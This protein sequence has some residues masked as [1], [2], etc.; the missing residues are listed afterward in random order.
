[1]TISETK[2]RELISSDEGQ[3]H[4][5]KSLLEGPPGR[6]RSRDRRAVRDQIA[7]Q[8]AGFAN[9][10]G[11]V[12]IFG[13]EDDL[14]I[15][16]HTYPADV[17][18]QMLAVPQT[19]LVPPLPNGYRFR[20]DGVELL[21]FEVECAPRAVMVQGDGYPYRIGD[22][23][24]QFS[25][26]KI[27]T[28]KDQGLVES[29]EA[30][31]SSVDIAALD[32]SLLERARDASGATDLSLEDYLVRRRIADRVGA[33]V[34]LREAAVFLF[35]L[36]PETIAHPNASVR[37][38]RV[39]GTERLTGTQ[40]NVQEFP[41]IEGNLPSVLQQARTLLGTLIQRSSR[42]HDLFFQEMPEY[43][44]FAWQEALVNAV[45]HRDYGIQ[46]QSVEV[47]LYDDRLEVWSPGG[48]PPEISI[49]ELRAGDPAHASRNPRI[50]RALADLGV[51]RDQGEGI[52]RMF[53]EMESSFLPLP[54][55]DVVAGR[56]RVVL[57][58][59]PIFRIDDPK[60]PQA[61]RALP[62]S[63]T[64]KRAMVGLVDRDFSNAD[65]CTLNAVDRDTAYRELHDLVERR[66]VQATG[67]GAGTRYRVMRGSV[68]AAVPTTAPPLERLVARMA[69]AGFITNTDYRD[70]FDVDRNAAKAV[71]ASWVG[72]GMLLREGRRRW[73]RYRPG[74]RWPPA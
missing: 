38:F 26:Q 39:A 28:I 37:I 31:R 24:S 60:W 36:R 41:R 55:L 48:L 18:D 5:R 49:D 65:Y 47:W 56:F 33:V 46:G 25:E 54:A 66:L 7:E 17:V 16:G 69:E 64:Q 29:A 4:D 15:S 68:E 27:N 8:V 30:R 23:T 63:L 70:A 20:L 21:V 32:T 11:G 67:S 34:V 57:Q 14:T 61:V 3:Y 42:L 13:V 22:A 73:T 6:K 43:P 51:M 59:N 40:H 62:I 10:D 2:L 45:A 74:D 52:P 58:N 72:Q 19:R 71:L 50:A 35:A 12:V 9:A 44:T 53:E 1:M